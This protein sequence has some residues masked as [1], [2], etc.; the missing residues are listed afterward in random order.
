MLKVTN[1]TFRTPFG[2]FKFCRLPYGVSC[3]PEIF[4]KAMAEIICDIEGVCLYID[5]LLTFSDTL[6][7]HNAILRKVLEKA[8]EIN[9]IS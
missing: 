9:A 6:E 3:A 1:K 4:H 7:G 2:R 8:W 5:D